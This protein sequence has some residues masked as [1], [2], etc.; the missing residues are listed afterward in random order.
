MGESLMSNTT[1][2]KAL[3]ASMVLIMAVSCTT[4]AS[5]GPDTSLNCPD[6]L[7]LSV[8]WVVD[9]DTF[10]SP[11]GRVRLYNVD[12]PESVQVVEGEYRHFEGEGQK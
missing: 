9:G 5:S 3:I 11:Q 8:E 10:D 6:C 2:I 4:M 12:T 7:L 1:K